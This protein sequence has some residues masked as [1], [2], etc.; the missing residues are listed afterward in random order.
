MLILKRAR[1]RAETS[2]HGSHLISRGVVLFW[3]REGAS[4]INKVCGL[5]VLVFCGLIF[6]LFGHTP[7]ATNPVL[8]NR[9]YVAYQN[10]PV[11]AMVRSSVV[12]AGLALSFCMADCFCPNARGAFSSGRS[13]VITATC[14][15]TL[16]HAAHARFALWFLDTALRTFVHRGNDSAQLRE[17]RLNALSKLQHVFTG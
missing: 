10:K 1:Q 13:Q 15:A 4:W 2:C 8:P 5:R 17:A 9:G 7:S 14:V 16:T 12:A 11:R 6:V 3:G